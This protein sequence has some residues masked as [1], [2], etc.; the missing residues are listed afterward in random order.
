MKSIHWTYA[1]IT[2]TPITSNTPKTSYH[3]IL[4]E[5]IVISHCVETIANHL[6]GTICAILA[7]LFI[8]ASFPVTQHII[9]HDR[10]YWFK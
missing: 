9:A 6:G 8:Y 1:C 3:H 10:Q 7:G 4:H 5:Y 2:I